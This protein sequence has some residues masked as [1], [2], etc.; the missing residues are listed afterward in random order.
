MALK[1]FNR[2]TSG[3]EELNRIQSNL[4]GAINPVVKKEILDGVLVSGTVTASTSS[5]AHGLGR[6]PRGW[7]VVSGHNDVGIAAAADENYIY[8]SSSGGTNTVSFWVF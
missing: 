6:V 2:L 5:V 8:V 3:S 4:E 1:P 7:F